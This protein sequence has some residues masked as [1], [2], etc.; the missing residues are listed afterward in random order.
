[1]PYQNDMATLADVVGGGSAALQ[2]GTQNELANQQ[3]A[4]K[5]QIQQA[6]MPQEIQRASLNNALLQAQGQA[7]Q[8]QAAQQQ[9]AGLTALQGQP[10]ASAA[11][12][13]GNQVKLSTAQM[14]QMSNL[15]N[16]VGQLAN[17][18]QNIPPP[19][20]PAFMQHFLDQHD[21]NDPGIRQ[22]VGGG[23]PEVLGK[24]SQG[25]FAASNQA[26]AI[27][28]QEGMRGDTARDVAN[29]SSEGRIEG[30]TIAAQAQIQKAEIAREYKEQAMTF[31]QRAAKAYAAGDFQTYSDLAK[32]AMNLR[33]LAAQNT[34]QLIMGTTPQI[35]VPPTPQQSGQSPQGGPDSNAVEAEMRKRGFIK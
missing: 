9:A 29:I 4:I 35:P 14:E 24:I 2:A 16:M 12:I 19:A 28:M 3:E 26:R 13:A 5:T 10:S 11:N 7:E 1:M 31:E 8:G 18:M 23:D 32:M 34:G 33:Q 20:R 30:Q 25:L 17:Y 21:I 27:Q 22:A 6:T 15:G